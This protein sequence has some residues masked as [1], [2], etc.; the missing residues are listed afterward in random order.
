MTSLCPTAARIGERNVTK[1]RLSHQVFAK[2]LRLATVAST[3]TLAGGALAVHS[4]SAQAAGTYNVANYGAVGDG[5]TDATGA[6]A[7]AIAAAEQNGGGTV[8][9]PAGVYAFTSA[10]ANKLSPS[11]QLDGQYPVAL[12]GAGRD[13]TSLVEHVPGMVLLSMHADGSS[14]R[15]LTLDSK[16]YNGG[17]VVG[18]QANNTTLDSDRILGGTT[19]FALFYRGQP[20]TEQDAPVYSTGNQVTNDIIT[21]GVQND[22]FSFSFQKDGTIANITHTGSRLALYVDDDVTVTNYTYAP[23][24]QPSATNGFWI[25]PPSQNITITNFTTSGE[26]GVVDGENGRMSSNISIINERFTSPGGDHLEIGNVN[27]LVVSGASFN[28]GNMLRVSPD[29]S[30]TGVVVENSNLAGVRFAGPTTATATVSFPNDTFGAFDPNGSPAPTFG[31]LTPINATATMSGGTWANSTGG[32]TLKSAVS[33][34][35]GS[36]TTIT[37][38]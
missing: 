3:L 18:D 34:S 15:G 24:P 31:C 13:S 2:A 11:I 12:V 9:V 6:F 21:D 16:T 28:T 22:G 37:C 5:V 23:G 26:G 7:A 1:H 20:G 29:T 32:L 19:D 30:A 38:A 35:H 25:T 10:G 4:A 14:V 27:G 33:S 36:T 8:V 17:V